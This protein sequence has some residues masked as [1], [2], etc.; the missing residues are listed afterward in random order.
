MRSLFPANNVSAMD[1]R[2][3]ESF[4]VTASRTER[5]KN[6]AVPYMQRLLNTAAK[7]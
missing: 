1:T 4:K 3:R 6:S 7:K 2:Y 5:H